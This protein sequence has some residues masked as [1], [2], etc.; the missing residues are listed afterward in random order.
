M[1]IITICTAIG[2]GITIATIIYQFGKYSERFGHLEDNYSSIKTIVDD[3][4][5]RVIR[6]EDV[7][8]IKYK[9]IEKV[10]SSKHSPRRLNEL[11][12]SY[13]AEMNGMQFLQDNKDVLFE[14]IDKCKPKAALDVEQAAL[15]ACAL[16]ESED[17]FIPIK[18]FIYNCPTKTDSNGNPIDITIEMAC[19]VL[20]IPLRDMYLEEHPEIPR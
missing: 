4:K 5:E 17:L 8:M 6:I 15:Y 18:T 16:Q 19:Y 10:L 13:F 12:N 20:S 11:G 9:D 7:L 2:T 3:L 1:D 14:A